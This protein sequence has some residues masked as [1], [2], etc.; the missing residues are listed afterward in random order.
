MR[1]VRRGNH[2]SEGTCRSGLVCKAH[3]RVCRS[4]AGSIVIKE[5]REDAVRGEAFGVW[6]PDHHAQGTCHQFSN[7]ISGGGQP[8]EGDSEFTPALVIS[9][10]SEDSAHVGAIGLALEP[11]AWYISQPGR[12]AV[13][14]EPVGTAAAVVLRC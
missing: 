1:S 14:I 12:V 6:G 5:R 10:G 9:A 7:V 3:R 11:F 13:R 4:T 2:H 8:L